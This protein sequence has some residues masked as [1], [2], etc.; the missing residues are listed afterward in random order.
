[1]VLLN[2]YTYNKQINKSWHYWQQTG[3][4]I[5]SYNKGY[6]ALVTKA[7]AFNSCIKVMH[8][9]TTTNICIINNSCMLNH[10]PNP[11]NYTSGSLISSMFSKNNRGKKGTFN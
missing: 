4:D 8:K 6:Y 3:I 11:S 9:N 10:K 1:M 7:L 5:P 2:K